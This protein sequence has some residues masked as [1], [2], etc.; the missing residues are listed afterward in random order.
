M[1]YGT[2]PYLEMARKK[3]AA[4]FTVYKVICQ[5]SVLDVLISLY[6]LYLLFSSVFSSNK[7][8]NAVSEHR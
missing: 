1:L 5:N 2:T 6:E 8:V 7:T 4:T 3:M